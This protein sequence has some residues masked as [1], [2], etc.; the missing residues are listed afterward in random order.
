MAEF[1]VG[2]Q[3]PSLIK[4]VPIPV[5]SVVTITTHDVL[6]RAVAPGEPSGVRIVHQTT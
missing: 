2:H 5:P 6:G 1:G 4:A 3:T